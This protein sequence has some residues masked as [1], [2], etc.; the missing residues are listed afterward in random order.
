[1]MKE[2]GKVLCRPIAGYE[3]NATSPAVHVLCKYA[4]LDSLRL[5]DCQRIVATWPSEIEEPVVLANR[6]Y[7]T[8]PDFVILHRYIS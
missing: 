2:T 8:P 4:N 3:E 7:L 1:M 6:A 5:A